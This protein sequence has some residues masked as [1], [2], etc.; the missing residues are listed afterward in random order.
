MY[1]LWNAKVA[2]KVVCEQISFKCCEVCGQGNK[3]K[4]FYTNYKIKA[5][6]YSQGVIFARTKS[7]NRNFIGEI[8]K[9][10]QSFVH[11]LLTY[12]K[13]SLIVIFSL[14]FRNFSLNFCTVSNPT[15]L[16]SA[17]FPLFAKHIIFLEVHKQATIE[18]LRNTNTD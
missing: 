3:T 10:S 13:F 17:A 7:E 8:F 18:Q 6:T 2:M 4:D 12:L 5:R 14:R 15:S 9:S 11:H 16:I 1:Q